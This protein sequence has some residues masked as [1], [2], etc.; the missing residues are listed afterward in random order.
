[1]VATGFVIWEILFALAFIGCLLG[2]GWTLRREGDIHPGWASCAIGV[3]ALASLFTLGYTVQAGEG[4]GSGTTTGVVANL[5]DQ[6]WPWQNREVWIVH[7]G[8]VKAERFGVD[9][10]DDELWAQLRAAM[11][12]EQRVRVTYTSSLFCAQWNQNNCDVIQSV[13]VL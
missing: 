13:E 4:N 2:I 1:M 5:G 8:E 3:L 10:D 12:G 7:D 6:G 9:Q 11:Q